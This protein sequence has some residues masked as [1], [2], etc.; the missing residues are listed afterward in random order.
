MR[1]TLRGIRSLVVLREPRQVLVLDPGHPGLVLLVVVL[2]GLL[3]V[4]LRLLVVV[5]HFEDLAR[6]CLRSGL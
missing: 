4:G 3:L 2:A 1:R 5:G 6:K